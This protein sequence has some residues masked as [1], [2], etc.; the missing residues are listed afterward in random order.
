MT[1]AAPAVVVPGYVPTPTPHPPAPLLAEPEAPPRRRSGMLVLTF[2]GLLVV[3]AILAV[4]ALSLL[5]DNNTRQTQT[6][7]AGL[8]Q[9]QAALQQTLDEL[10]AIAVL[11]SISPT[12]PT[13]VQIV[14]TATATSRATST[15]TPTATSTP[16]ATATLTETPTATLSKTPTL[17]STPTS[18]LT[19]TPTHTPTTGLETLIAA[20]L[21]PG[22]TETAIAEQIEQTVNAIFLANQATSTAVMATQIAEAEQTQAVLSTRTAEAEQAQAVLATRTAQAQQTQIAANIAMEATNNALQLMGTL[23]A[24]RTA[25]AASQQTAAALQTL[26]AYVSPTSPAGSC[27]NFL[28]SRLVIG[29]YAR[30]TPGDPNRLRSAPNS[31]DVLATIPGG[32]PIKVLDG[33]TCTISGDG[34]G[35][36]W[37]KVDWQGTQG[38]TAE[39]KGNTYWIEPLGPVLP[40]TYVVQR[41]PPPANQRKVAPPGSTLLGDFQVEWYCNDR[42]YN[43]TLVNGQRDWACLNKSDNSVAF[44]L[45]ASDFDAICRSWYNDTSAFAIQDMT[46]DIAAYNWRCYTF[47]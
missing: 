42:G 3:I 13:L 16:S 1:A 6:A 27:P 37:W 15:E 22:R 7:A 36:A 8:R 19:S 47:R 24:G 38:W 31:S 28:P 10:T 45:R 30:I 25:I 41:T 33:P 14:A 21:A 4:A 5:N 17:T 26:A 46:K 29:E 35:I 32:S 23:N 39:G 18:T 11:P 2:V 34:D 43:V 12:S 9:T 20:T 44:V 40:P